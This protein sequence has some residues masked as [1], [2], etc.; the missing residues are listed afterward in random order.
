MID[1]TAQVKDRWMNKIQLLGVGRE[2]RMGEKV[3]A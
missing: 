2:K 3:M 1:V